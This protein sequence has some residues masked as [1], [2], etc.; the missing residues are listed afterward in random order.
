MRI[1]GKSRTHFHG[2]HKGCYI[3]IY[4]EADSFLRENGR[5]FYIIVTAPSGGYLCDGWT[6]DH[7]VTMADAK[8]EALYGAGLKARPTNHTGQAGEGDDRG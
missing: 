2:T 8:R 6:R 3:Q 1:V 5:R 7:V 4:R